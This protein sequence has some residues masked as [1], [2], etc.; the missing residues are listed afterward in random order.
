MRK[1]LAAALI[2]GLFGTPA[3]AQ[4]PEKVL[5]FNEA[6]GVYAEA[7]QSG[8][9]SAAIRASKNVLDRGRAIFPDS[10]E[11]IALLTRNH[12]AALL[13]GGDKEAASE[14]LKDALNR[15]EDIY[16][17]SSVKLIPVLVEYAD[18]NSEPFR[19]AD[20][21]RIY[22]RALKIVASQYG[23]DS[24]EYAELS[25]R[26]GKNSY[27]LS[28]A[29]WAEKYV[30]KACDL[31]EKHY[32]VPD[33]R[34]GMCNVTLGQTQMSDGFFTQ[35]VPYFEKALIP[36]TDDTD[37]DRSYRVK[38][39]SLL[40]HSFEESGK[41]DRATEQ[42]RAI[43]EDMQDMPEIA[44]V[45]IYQVRP[46]YPEQLRA[47]GIEGQVVLKLTVDE[48]GFVQ[49]VV[50]DETIAI[51]NGRRATGSEF[52]SFDRQAVAAVKRYRYA[53][54]Y[55]SGQPQKT[56]D[57]TAKIT[58][59]LRQG[60]LVVDALSDKPERPSQP[61]SPE[62]RRKQESQTSTAPRR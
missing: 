6:W 17:N 34:T 15:Y 2:L 21:L 32:G 60:P 11:R 59:A 9:V 40:V 48:S 55:S 3:S 20:Q 52:K 24:P 29:G 27:E 58:F 22:K 43:G 25:F 13:A 35:S 10:D 26:T 56:S 62:F 37:A 44:M 53:P 12:G 57:V 14:H 33:R 28:R 30:R 49:D 19:P 4:D 39:R 54:R 61:P 46:E 5:A 51:E 18:A 42:L 38:I 23:S 7:A 47:Q 1:L 16:G 45:P 36:F 31:F 8:D 41:Q 50:V